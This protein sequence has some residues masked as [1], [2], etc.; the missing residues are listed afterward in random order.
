MTNIHLKPKKIR[1]IS[2]KLPI[3]NF[4][5]IEIIVRPLKWP[6]LGLCKK[7]KCL[8]RQPVQPDPIRVGSLSDVGQI[9]WVRHLM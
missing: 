1:N 8:T 7:A 9:G 3:E 4:K 2:P 5:M 6:I